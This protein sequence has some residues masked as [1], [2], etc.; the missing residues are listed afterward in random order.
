MLDT[1]RCPGCGAGVVG[2]G[3][4]SR[5]SD[6]AHHVVR[7]FVYQLCLNQA[8]S[9]K[10]SDGGRRSGR[11]RFPEQSGGE[12]RPAPDWLHFLR[13]PTPVQVPR[14]QCS[15]QD[16]LAYKCNEYLKCA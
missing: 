5:S 1:S 6:C 2:V 7:A 15:L 10:G 12:R 16:P 14:S 3:V 13:S 11:L 4:C 9:E 8:A